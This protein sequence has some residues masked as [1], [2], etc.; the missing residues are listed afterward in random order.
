MTG[1]YEDNI[2]YLKEFDEA[3]EHEILIPLTMEIREQNKLREGQ[4]DLYINSPGGYIYLMQHIVELIEL[5]KE[6]GTIVRTIVPEMAYSAGSMVAIAGSPGERYIGRRAE[7]LAHYGASINFQTTP[8]Q[9]ERFAEQTK[10][11]FAHN[12]AHYKKYCDI[13]NLDSEMLDDGFY[14]PAAKAIKYKM[15]DKYMDKL[16]V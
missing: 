7:H 5:A 9:A 11:S 12:L 10:R 16:E 15:A 6:Q 1:M 8:L 13:P 4:I 3:M 14:I 2:F